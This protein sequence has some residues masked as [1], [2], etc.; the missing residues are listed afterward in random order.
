[1]VIIIIAAGWQVVKLGGN[2]N[3]GANAGVTYLNAD[4]A[5]SNLNRNISSHLSCFKVL[6]YDNLGSCQNIN[7]LTSVSR[8]KS[9]ALR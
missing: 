7:N 3:N 8:V 2:T 1:M 9:K 5:S 4:N 6:N